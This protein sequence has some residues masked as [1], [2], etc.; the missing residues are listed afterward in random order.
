V[1]IE[2]A[3]TCSSEHRVRSSIIEAVL[4]AVGDI[5]ATAGISIKTALKNGDSDGTSRT[6]CRAAQRVVLHE[7]SRCEWRNYG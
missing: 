7:I 3:T 1:V 4:V 5:H 2:R 6:E